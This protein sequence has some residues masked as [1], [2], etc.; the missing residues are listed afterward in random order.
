[1]SNLIRQG[2]YKRDLAV[3]IHNFRGA[4]LGLVAFGNIARNVLGKAVPFGFRIIERVLP[5]VEN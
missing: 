1:M 3:P 2:V 4:T 5:L